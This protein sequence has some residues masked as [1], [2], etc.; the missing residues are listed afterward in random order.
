MYCL[1]CVELRVAKHHFTHCPFYIWLRQ[2][3]PALVVYPPFD[4]PHMLPCRGTCHDRTQF[5]HEPCQVVKQNLSLFIHDILQ[6]R[7]H[8]ALLRPVHISLREGS[9]GMVMLLFIKWQEAISA[10]KYDLHDE[11]Q[12][13]QPEGAFTQRNSLFMVLKAGPTILPSAT[14]TLEKASMTWKRSFLAASSCCM[15]QN[16]LSIMKQALYTGP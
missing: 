4:A 7:F 15:S 5:L 3:V 13:D 14:F 10:K 16:T 1:R 12:H 8:P 2:S 11:K 6:E 9:L